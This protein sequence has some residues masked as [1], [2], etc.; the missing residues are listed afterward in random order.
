L[1][2]QKLQSGILTTSNLPSR[3][4]TVVLKND[5]ALGILVINQV[6]DWHSIKIC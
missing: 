3:L 2:A 6:G 1:V 4:L 5:W